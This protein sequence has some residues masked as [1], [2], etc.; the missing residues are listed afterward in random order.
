M[1]KNP[2]ERLMA[3]HGGVLSID[4]KGGSDA[5][6]MLGDNSSEEGKAASSYGWGWLATAGMDGTVKVGH[7]THTIFRARTKPLYATLDLGHVC[8][9]SYASDSP[10]SARGATITF[11]SL[12][13]RP[14]QALRRDS[15]T[16]GYRIEC[17]YSRRL[18]AARCGNM[19]CQTRALTEADLL[20]GWLAS[21]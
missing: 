13:N 1:P 20:V 21:L 12:V 6:Q 17:R 4:W 19:G 3:H 14:K 10:Y 5:S 11:C 7:L 18:L 16:Y 8:I 15:D 2:V 9:V